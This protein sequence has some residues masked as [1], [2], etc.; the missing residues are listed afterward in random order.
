MMGYN[1]F[2][3]NM[4]FG[5]GIFGLMLMILFWGV[6]IW[7]IFWLIKQNMHTSNVYSASNKHSTSNNT[8]QSPKEL[9]QLR[10]VNGEITKKEYHEMKTEL[11]D[12]LT[13]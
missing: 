2:G 7:L 10:F 8:Y 4:G 6:I 13:F 5:V 3:W 11:E 1:D 9:L 12:N